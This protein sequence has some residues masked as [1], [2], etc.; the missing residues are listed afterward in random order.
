[1]IG[2]RYYVITVIGVISTPLFAYA[3]GVTGVIFMHIDKF[4][5]DKKLKIHTLPV[6]IGERTARITLVIMLVLQ[7]LFTF[8]LVIMGYYTLVMAAVVLAIPTFRK[9]LPM[10]KAPRPEE[11][12]ADYPDVWPNYFVAAAFIHNRSFGIWFMLALIVD[13]ILKVYIL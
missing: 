10:F 11:K 12:P 2:G 8:V 6:V 1:M 3:L 7:Y 4:E 5:M 13:S 9:I